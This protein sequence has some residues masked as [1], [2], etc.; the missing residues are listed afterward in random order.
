MSVSAFSVFFRCLEVHNKDL[1]MIS[2]RGCATLGNLPRDHWFVD[3]YPIGSI[4]Y[5]CIFTYIF[6]VDFCLLYIPLHLWLIFDFLMYRSWIYNRPMKNLR[7]RY[8]HLPHCPSL[9]L[10]ANGR[11]R[12]SEQRASEAEAKVATKRIGESCE[13]CGSLCWVGMYFFYVFWCIYIFLIYMNAGLMVVYQGTKWTITLS[14]SKYLPSLK[15]T[16]KAPENGPKPK[17]KRSS[18]NHP[19]SGVLAVSFREGIFYGYILI[20]YIY[21]YIGWW[22]WIFILRCIVI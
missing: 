4:S 5:I 20:L 16:A 13:F 18:S 11:L 6:M 3:H 10:P 14:K 21:I 2:K 8:L 22:P 12:N 7:Y 9:A 15:L 1:L 17:R 19:F